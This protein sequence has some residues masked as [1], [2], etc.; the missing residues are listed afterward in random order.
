[1]VRTNHADL[2]E[3]VQL[4]RDHATIAA[5]KA[6]TL[7][8]LEEKMQVFPEAP[9]PYFWR[10]LHRAARGQ[11]ASATLDFQ[12]ALKAAETSSAPQVGFLPSL[13]KSRRYAFQIAYLERYLIICVL[14]LH[15]NNNSK[16]NL[17]VLFSARCANYGVSYYGQCCVFTLW[18]QPTSFPK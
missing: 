13:L 3:A 16:Y 17:L 9:K 12:R 18:V 15:T 11:H 8:R 1:M 14:I 5:M 2:Y 10:G 4:L 6:V 7:T